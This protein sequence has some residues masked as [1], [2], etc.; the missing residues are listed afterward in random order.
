[1]ELGRIRGTVVCTVCDPQLR[2]LRL[3]LVEPTDRD[4]F[5]L[6]TLLVAADA[7]GARAG[8]LVCYETAREAPCAFPGEPPID[9][10]V[11]GILDP[12]TT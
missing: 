6:G 11:I 5:R 8:Q 7:V 4:G 3:V 10:A 9:A 2:G 1:M 12:V